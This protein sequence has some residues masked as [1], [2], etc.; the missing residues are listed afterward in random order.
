MAEWQRLC[1]AKRDITYSELVGKKDSE[2]NDPVLVRAGTVGTIK[3]YID[4][5]TTGTMW[6][7]VWYY[8]AVAWMI[9]AE[10]IEP[11]VGMEV[12]NDH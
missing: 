10:L 12:A 1:R 11:V 9:P 4:Y 2:G 5:P 3:E 8:G 7:Y 6:L